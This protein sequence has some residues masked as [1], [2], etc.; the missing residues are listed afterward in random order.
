[1]TWDTRTMYFQIE[2]YQL[3]IDSGFLL[4]NAAKNQAF[5]FGLT[6]I[7]VEQYLIPAEIRIEIWSY[8]NQNNSK[9]LTSL[10]K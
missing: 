10:T 4:Q 1:M 8:R 6:G 2:L 9:L 7:E 5:E 3:S